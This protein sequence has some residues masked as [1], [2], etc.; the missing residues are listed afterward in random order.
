MLSRNVFLISILLTL[1]ACGGQQE[2]SSGLEEGV[3][4]LLKS[5]VLVGS[6]IMV[7]G[8]RMLIVTADDLYTGVTKV[9]GTKKR[10]DDKL[11]KVALE[12]TP[13]SH[14]VSVLINGAQIYASELY[15]S[16]GQTRDIR[17]RQ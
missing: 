10:E 17:I 13:G 11:Q 2:K 6:E 3:L 8:K 14:T 15:F 5:E 4:L 1:A 9:W 7:D 16:A 12:L